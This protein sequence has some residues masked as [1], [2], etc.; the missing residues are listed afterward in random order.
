MGVQRRWAGLGI[1]I[2][3]DTERGGGGEGV[4]HGMYRL[5][6]EFY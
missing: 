5:L 6:E 1:A 3:K 4:Y 2:L